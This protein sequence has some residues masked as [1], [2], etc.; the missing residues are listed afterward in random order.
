MAENSQKENGLSPFLDVEKRL[1]DL[2]G[3]HIL[4]D[5]DVAELYGVPTEVVNQVVRNN[6][7]MFPDA[8]ILELS[9]DESAVLR[10]KFLTLEQID[11][12]GHYSKYNYKAFTERGLYMLATILKS[13]QA[14]EATIA[15]IETFAKVRHLLKT[16]KGYDLLVSVVDQRSLR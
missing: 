5:K 11:G 4:L 1:L 3:Q 6:P 12:K 10:S 9:K 16:R 14:T 7:D 15:I 2:R 13:P 8:Y